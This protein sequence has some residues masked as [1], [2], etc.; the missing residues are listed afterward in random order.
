MNYTYD[1]RR[2][3]ENT[4][5]HTETTVKQPSL[6]ALRSGTAEPTRE[7]MGHRVDLPDAMRKKMENAFGADF[8]AVKLYESR[9]VADA[10]A[11]AVTRGSEIAFAPGMLD[12]TS[13]SGQ[14]LLGHEL[15]HV[16][17][18]SRGEA[19]GSGFLRDSAL[20]AKADREGALAAAGQT[21]AAPQEALSSAGTAPAVAPMQAGLKKPKNK[22]QA[23]SDDAA[24]KSGAVTAASLPP[25]ASTVTESTAVSAPGSSLSGSAASMSSSASSRGSSSLSGSASSMSSSASSVGASSMS[26]SA[27]GSVPQGSAAPRAGLPPVESVRTQTT[28]VPPAGA[29]Q[30]PQAGNA[31]PWRFTS[32]PNEQRAL[33]ANGVGFLLGMEN[34]DH[35][36]P[37]HR[38]AF[39]GVLR[40]MKGIAVVTGNRRHIGGQA[41][42][43]AMMGNA[44]Q[45]AIDGLVQYRTML[46]QEF[47]ENVHYM[48]DAEAQRRIA[49]VKL[50]N[51][52]I[53]RARS[54]QRVNLQRRETTL[55]PGEHVGGGG[56]GAINQVHRFKRGQGANRATAYFKPTLPDDQRTKRSVDTE[57]SVMDRIG[58]QHHDAQGAPLDARL[59]KREV[60]YSRLSSLMGSSVGIGAKLAKYQDSQQ[61]LHGV[62]M[63]E[64]KGKLWTDYNWQYF[65]PDA[66]TTLSCLDPATANGTRPGA[67]WGERLNGTPIV[68]KSTQDH[69]LAQEAL[70]I[71][72]NAPELDAA[73]PDYQ[74][75]M[76]EMFLLDTLATHTDR[77]GGNY[78]VNRDENG[79]ISV[80]TMDNDI[81]FG[82][83]RSEEADQ[84]AFGKRGES[85]NY[86]G[87]PAKMQID[88]NMAKKIRGM[89]KEMLYKTF[90]DLLSKD[91]I[92][93]LWTRFEMMK[94]YVD[95]MEKEHLIVDH[96]DEQT[97]KRE[98]SLAGGALSYNQ[99]DKQRPK[100][101]S[102]NNYYQRQMLML[103]AADSKHVVNGE[104][105]LQIAAGNSWGIK[106]M[107]DVGTDDPGP[108]IVVSSED[109]RKR[110]SF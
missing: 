64:A 48:S 35:P 50:V 36:D 96:W 105:F 84:T 28:T 42:Y 31:D 83:F 14:A 73:D 89:K 20:E 43:D 3:A 98:T 104:D 110:R 24:P 22:Q 39:M 80:K 62:L 61:Q 44:Y 4:A 66:E 46:R 67:N 82:S 95:A 17:S 86:G 77:H 72:E 70:D 34:L 1:N 69:D 13:F 40:G 30:N 49:H 45:G 59:S 6:E 91:E 78:H 12:F 53:A 103:H 56:H 100:G 32:S 81:T 92:E 52:L 10:G 7:Q 51:E 74:R 26:S 37:R 47:M 55:R 109:D 16:V 88:A 101:Y 87:L 18:Q 8:S 23:P 57:H 99:E 107:K 19:R 29:P 85:F 33:P 15:S 38:N 60:A 108:E 41:A 71:P 63:E 5:Q 76:N 27:S 68:R 11:G 106:H 97:A 94:E 58:I 93:S 75:Q 90:S 54:D 65:G 2:Q 21:V 25:E 102:G 79:K 9:A